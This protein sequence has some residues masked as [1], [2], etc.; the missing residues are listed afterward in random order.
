MIP[1]PPDKKEIKRY[2]SNTKIK[3]ILFKM[4]LNMNK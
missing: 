3:T 2:E 1:H 4:Q